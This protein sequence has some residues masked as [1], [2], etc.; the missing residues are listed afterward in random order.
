VG[1]QPAGQGVSGPAGR[2]ALLYACRRRSSACSSSTD[3]APS[4][5]APSSGAALAPSGTDARRGAREAPRQPDALL[6]GAR[7]AGGRGAQQKGA[8]L[9][10]SPQKQPLERSQAQQDY[11]EVHA[12]ARSE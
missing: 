6:R 3:T 11:V 4:A 7:R 12:A 1:A 2:A 9:A 5:P 10:Q 8:W